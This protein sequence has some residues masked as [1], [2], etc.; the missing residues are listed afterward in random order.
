MRNPYEVLIKPVVSEKST[1]LMEENKY[2]FKVDP[3]ANKIEI[4]H[5]VETAFKVN[6]IDVKTMRV[7][8]KLKRQ[9]RTQGYT[10]SWKKAIVTVKAGQRLPIFEE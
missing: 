7:P 1:S 3:R 10:P 4:K 9:G 6:V 2:T 8:G 5:A